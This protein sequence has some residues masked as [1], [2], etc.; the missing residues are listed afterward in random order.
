MNCRLVGLPDLKTESTYVQAQIKNYLNKLVAMGVDGFRFDAAKHMQPSRHRRD[1]GRRDHAPP[2]GESLWVT[3][4]SH[5]GQQRG[6]LDYFTNGTLNEFQFTYAHARRP[7]A[8]TTAPACRRSAPSW[9]RRATGAAPGALC[10]ATRQPCSSTTGTPSATA[11]RWSPATTSRA[12][13]NDT[14]G[15]KRYDLANIF[16]LAWPY[17][18]AQL[19]SG[20]RF[21][22]YDQAPPS[23]SPFDAS[24][25]PLINQSW[26]FIHRWSDISNMVKFRSTTSGQ[27]VDNFTSGTGNQIAFSP[28]QQGL[29]RDQ[30]RWRGVE[31]L[32][33]NPAACGHLLQ[34]GQGQLN[35]AGTACTSDSVTVGGNGNVTITLPADGGSSMPAVAM[36]TGQKVS[37]G[38]GGGTAR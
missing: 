3:Q 38:G 33:A 20:F 30:Q 19:H 34:R 7:S 27:G 32:A 10:R 11:A 35:A 5:P 17:G 6:A 4:E 2:P 9:A 23:A 37:G 14:Q 21:T 18:H 16:M 31:R 1:P 22:N 24:G 36:H 29:C 26:D 28:R 15:T 13:T 8:T 25:N 12:A